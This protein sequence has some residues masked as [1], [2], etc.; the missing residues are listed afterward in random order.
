MLT[1]EDREIL[2][3]TADYAMQFVFD[4]E[5]DDILCQLTSIL[6]GMMQ[7]ICERD[8]RELVGMPQDQRVE[9][10]TSNI[11]HTSR[12]GPASGMPTLGGSRG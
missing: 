10:A 7:R 1:K 8:R 9:T 3:R 6:V 4:N 2:Q 5:E 12:I 11:N